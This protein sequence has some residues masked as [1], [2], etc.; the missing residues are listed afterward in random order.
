[1]NEKLKACPFCRG[2]AKLVVKDWDNKSDEYKVK[3][4]ECGVEQSE[5]TYN[6]AEAI[7]NWNRRSVIEN[8]VDKIKEYQATVPAN[9]K[10]YITGLLNLI[11]I[12]DKDE[13]GNSNENDIG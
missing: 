8:I 7:W 3:C 6:K 11:D 9:V 1:M 4:S 2:K 13:G 10:K 12:E 5:Y